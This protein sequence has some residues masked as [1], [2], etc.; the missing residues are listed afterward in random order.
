MEKSVI[1]QMPRDLNDGPQLSSATA[2]QVVRHHLRLFGVRGN[3]PLVLYRADADD[4]ERTNSSCAAGVPVVIIDPTE[5]FC[6]AFAVKRLRQAGA[7]P[8]IFSL[9]FDLTERWRRLRTLHRYSSFSN[10]AGAPVVTDEKSEAA[11]LWT[12]HGQSGVLWVG[13][14]LGEDLTRYR[15]GD[16]ACA[17]DRDDNAKWGFS[18]ERPLYLFEPQLGDEAPDERHA[19]WWAMALVRA[20]SVYGGVK[21][22]P[23]LPGGAP[24]AV[25]L[26]GDDD[27]ALLENYTRQLAATD[28]L[29]IT[30]FLH[31]QTKHDRSTLAR[32]FSGKN[33]DIGLH[34]DALDAP[35][36]YNSLFREQNAW[37]RELCGQAA[38]SVRNHGFLNDGYWGHLPVWLDNNVR[39]SS[40]L[41]GLNGRVLNGSL[42]PGRMVWEDQ[43]TSHWSALTA[44]G[45][46]VIFALGLSPE[47]AAGLVLDTAEA[48][49]TS[50][51]PGMMILNL[52]PDNI[53]KT[54]LMHNALQQVVEGGFVAW[55]VRDCVNWFD[56]NEPDLKILSTAGS[57]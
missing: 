44:I 20:L 49:R 5:T 9:T 37:Y 2:E 47:E 55:T 22:E 4:V 42:L 13:T 1:T 48:I 45:D 54:E 27:Q 16:P 57:F 7:P 12:P 31:P 53:A 11:W 43:L 15:Q 3:Q 33:V 30:Y 41:P 32:M 34:P 46:G 23:I 50:G 18:G 10:Q 14:A 36:Q 52:H 38:F 56:R 24:G 29:P 19:D 39:F 21:A 40:N 35:D 8:H 25:I 26:T 51:A 17:K 6:N 28:N